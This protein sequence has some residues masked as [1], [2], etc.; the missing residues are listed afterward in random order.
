[1]SADILRDLYEERAFSI[2]ELAVM[3]G[4]ISDT[5]A[6]RYFGETE[7]RFGQLM[8]LMHNAKCE[9]VRERF[10]TE[11]CSGSGWLVT[12]LP[13]D[14]DMNGDGAVDSNDALGK[15]ITLVERAAGAMRELTNDQAG[16]EHHQAARVI[17]NRLVADALAAVAIIDFIEAHRPR[18][19]KAR[20]V[21]HG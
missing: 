14:L 7:I 11:L 9:R 20:E 4:G 15:V 13:E 2:R 21:R 18:R 3:L 10:L 16:D 1:M 5:A 12:R 8:G 17:L 6:Y 19:R